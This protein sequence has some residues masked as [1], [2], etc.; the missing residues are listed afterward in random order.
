MH[1]KEM[2]NHISDYYK[3]QGFNVFKEIPFLEK[4]IDLLCVNKD[5][6]LSIELKIKDWKRV[7][8]QAYINQLFTTKSYVCIWHKTLNCIDKN[9]FAKFG[10]G[11]ISMDEKSNFITILEAKKSKYMYSELLEKLKEKLGIKREN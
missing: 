7:L 10:I 11:I 6:I 2:Q 8:W 3:K 4:R 5:Q 9:E 1:E